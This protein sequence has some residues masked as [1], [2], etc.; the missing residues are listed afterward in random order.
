M[1]FAEG[2][3]E[4]VSF[5]ESWLVGDRDSDIEAG[6]AAGCRAIFIDRGWSDE[7]GSRAGTVVL[8]LAEAVDAILA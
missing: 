4:P 1:L 2:E 5:E 3:I 8:S 7:T 6:L